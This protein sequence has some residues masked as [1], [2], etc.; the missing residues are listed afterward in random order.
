MHAKE[1]LVGRV[2][3]FQAYEEQPRDSDGDYYQVGVFFAG[4]PAALSFRRRDGF[5]IDDD[6]EFLGHFYW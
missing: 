4:R 2:C 1:R 3:I 6:A 5:I